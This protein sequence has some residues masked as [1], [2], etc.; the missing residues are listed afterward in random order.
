[1]GDGG[2]RLV[3]S[4]GQFDFEL[5]LLLFTAIHLISPDARA[6]WLHLHVILGFYLLLITQLSIHL[7]SPD[8]RVGICLASTTL[9]GSP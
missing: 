4:D 7:I 9:V 1:M 8:A 2:L 6:G 5:T 3:L